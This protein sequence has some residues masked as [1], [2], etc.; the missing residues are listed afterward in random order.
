MIVGYGILAFRDGYGIRPLILGSRQRPD[1]KSV[2]VASESV[3]LDVLGYDVVGDVKPGEAVWSN[4]S[5]V[6]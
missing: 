2:M 3:A 6:S 1:G 4:V 5:P